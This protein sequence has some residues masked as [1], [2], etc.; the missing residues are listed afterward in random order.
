MNYKL[1]FKIIEEFGT[2]SV[3]ARECGRSDNWLSRIITGRQKPTEKER[4]IIAKKLGV[5][6]IEAYLTCGG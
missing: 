4:D 5:E 3:F 1:K 2:Q 6:N